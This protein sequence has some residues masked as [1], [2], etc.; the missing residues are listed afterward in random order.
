MKLGLGIDTGGTYTDGVIYNFETEEVLLGVK[1]VTVKEDLKLGILEILDKLPKEFLAKV[2]M[3]S[4][5]TTLAT[6]ACVEDKGSRAKLILIGC[7]RRTVKRNGNGYGLPEAEDIIFIEGGHDSRGDIISEP[8]W[9]KLLLKAKEK[10]VD[11]YAIVQMWGMRNPEFEIKAKEL[12][13]EDTGL[14]V[15]CGHEL[16][17][18]LNFLK[19]A[20]TALLN[21][22]LIPLINEFIDAVKVG[23][24]E[25]DID[26][27]LAIVCGD[28][29]IMSEE[30]VRNRPVETLLSGPAASIIG[31]INLSQTQDAIVVDMG[32]TTSDLAIVKDGLPRLSPSGA[33]VGNWDTAIKSVDIRTIGLGGDS[34][35]SFDSMDRITIGP[36]RAAPLS[37]LCHRWPKVL[38]KLEAIRDNNRVH[39]RD[40]GQFFYKVRDIREEDDFSKEEKELVDALSD[41]PLSLEDL[42]LTL[43]S[44]IYTLTIERLE[45]L[46]IIMRSALT[47]TDIMHIDGEFIAWNKEAAILSAEIM[48]NR[49]GVSVEKIVKEVDELIKSRLY[50]S[51]VKELLKLEGLEEEADMEEEL[52]DK[53]LLKGFK[54]DG[55]KRSF[56]SL[57]LRTKFSLIGIGAPIHVYLPEIAKA[58]KADLIINEYAA[59]A[60][61][62]GAIT[63]SVTASEK[64]LIKPR[65]AA[66]G[67]DGYDCFSPR[68]KMYFEDYEMAKKWAIKEIKELVA[69]MAVA[70]GSKNYDIRLDLEENNTKINVFSTELGEDKE[71]KTTREMLLET[72][73]RAT[74]VGGL[75]WI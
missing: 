38:D 1:A 35:I 8:D 49:L 51:I 69:E 19:R 72:K 63:A 60:N 37:W 47:P 31:G 21:A 62:V 23:L 16:A 14:P 2:G 43:N 25:R 70:K 56:L 71:I 55:D 52:L 45:E 28:G 4:L 59:V 30:F 73:I 50:L 58:L 74:A 67:I 6:N 54:N 66:L 41:G 36:R 7:D 57:N 34:L 27:P 5:S 48:A 3:V 15:I 32:G 18:E 26:V 17:S 39:T 40:L 68:K 33:K 20:S 13:M 29:S 24:R 11:S 53:I 42:A 64:V 75:D 10:N 22:R 9:D 46:G 12:L 44:T 65:Y 61:A